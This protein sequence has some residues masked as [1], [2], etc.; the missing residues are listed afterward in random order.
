MKYKLKELKIENIDIDV[1]ENDNIILEKIFKN[2]TKKREELYNYIIIEKYV[3]MDLDFITSINKIEDAVYNKNNYNEWK[4]N[5]YENTRKIL[6]EIVNE[7]I[8]KD[9]DIQT[10]ENVWVTINLDELY[11]IKLI[12]IKEEEIKK[13]LPKTK[14]YDIAEKIINN[15]IIITT[16]KRN[17]DIIFYSK[18]WK[19]DKNE[20]IE[21]VVKFTKG[22]KI[23][24]KPNLVKNLKKLLYNRK[25]YTKNPII[26][27][28]KKIENNYDFLDNKNFTSPIWVNF[29]KIEFDENLKILKEKIDYDKTIKTIN[30]LN[31][32]KLSVNKSIFEKIYKIANNSDSTGWLLT[33]ENKIKKNIY[34]IGEKEKNTIIINEWDDVDNIDIIKYSNSAAN[35]ELIKNQIERI[36]KYDGFFYLSYRLDSRYRIYVYNIPINYQLS[37]IVRACIKIEEKI[38]INNIYK[39][40]EENETIKKNLYSKEIFIQENLNKEIVIKIEKELKIEYNKELEKKLKIESFIIIAMGFAPKRIRKTEE[41]INFLLNKWEEFIN[42]DITKNWKKWVDILEIK[43]K[44]IF[45]IIS[46]QECLINIKKDDYTTTYWCDASSN[47]L[48][49]ITLRMG[50]IN[51]KLLMLTNIINNE[52]NYS[53]IYEYITE[54][55]KKDDHSSIIRKIN[56]KITNDELKKIITEDDTKKRAMPA[57]YGKTMYSNRIDTERSMVEDNRITIWE[58]MNKN[59]KK[60]ISDYLWIK[61]FEHLKKIGYDLEEYKNLF[62]KEKTEIYNWYNDYGLPVI[63]IK[64]KKS[65]RSE[66]LKKISKLKYIESTKIKR[67]DIENIEEKIK[68]YKEKIKED[69]RIFWKRTKIKVYEETYTIRIKKKSK[70]VDKRR[71]NLSVVPNSIH[72]YDSSIMFK[73][74]E[75]CKELGIKILTIH[76]SIGSSIILMPLVKIVFKISNIYFIKESAKQPPFPFKKKIEYENIEDIFKKIIESRDFFK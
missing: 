36:I 65:K 10:N 20:E 52:T 49:L 53:G 32:T 4:F 62:K 18:Q 9:I 3:D 22:Y 27:K 40:F 38:N 56:N 12:N 14:D 69:E 45:T 46:I 8:K 30:Y 35:L 72:S 66:M 67:E 76:D 60:E 50:K 2:V 57:S 25:V 75:I 51:E 7:M 63:P 37:H 74:I 44:K 28:I 58:K 55:I 6:E 34:E 70:N 33:T 19:S 21:D 5:I 24:L 54:E 68:N 17:K 13:I 15:N 43:N 71:I 11:N 48:Q 42:E 73:V 47:A 26:V 1:K 41:K 39:L 31:D 23:C 29:E 64:Y 16:L 61:T 59:E